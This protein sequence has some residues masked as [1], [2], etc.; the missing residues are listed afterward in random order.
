MLD[1]IKV[2]KNNI[3]FIDKRMKNENFQIM[4]KYLQRF[5]KFSCDNLCGDF[6]IIWFYF[7]K[8][9]PYFVAY[10]CFCDS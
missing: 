7:L 9:R 1:K 3:N 2:N 5:G 10:R 4:K 8:Q 6:F